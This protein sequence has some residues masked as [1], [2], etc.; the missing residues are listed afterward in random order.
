MKIEV[1]VVCG[2]FSPEKEVSLSTGKQISKHLNRN[3][4]NVRVIE[5]LRKQ[6]LKVF[7]TYKN[8]KSLIVFN[9]L[10]GTFGE[11]GSFQKFLD[12]LGILYTGCGYISSKLCM[13]KKATKKIL[14]GIHILQPDY[15]IYSKSNYKNFVLTQK[16]IF[17]PTSQGSSIGVSIVSS[18]NEVKSAFTKAFQYGNE[19]LVED[20]IDGTEITCSVI[21]NKNPEVLPIIEIVPSGYEFYNYDSKYKVGGSIHRIPAR[22]KRTIYKKTQE[23]ALRVYEGMGCEVYARIDMIVKNNEVYVLEVNTLPGMT[24]TSLLPQAAKACGISFSSLLDK[25]VVASLLKY[26]S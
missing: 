5:L 6:D 11:D 17:K 15:A 20:Y 22:L 23:I 13:D 12:K 24:E 14:S 18:K 9:A 25:I 7:E 3:K 21:G 19:V 1:L 26:Q 10:H 4:Y 8:G 2:G 16:S